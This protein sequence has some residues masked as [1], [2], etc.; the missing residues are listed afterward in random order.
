MKPNPY[1]DHQL[2]MAPFAVAAVLLLHVPRAHAN[3]FDIHCDPEGPLS[4]YSI[5]VSGELGTVFH[6]LVRQAGTNRV[7]ELVG[8]PAFVLEPGNHWIDVGALASTGFGSLDFWGQN[9]CPTPGWAAVQVRTLLLFDKSIALARS[10]TSA[11]KASMIR[12]GC[13]VNESI[14]VRETNS[15]YASVTGLTGPIPSGRAFAMTWA[16]VQPQAIAIQQEV[17]ARAVMTRVFPDCSVSSFRGDG[18]SQVEHL[19]VEVAQFT[20]C[21]V[22]QTV[23]RAVGAGGT[24]PTLDREALAPVSV[25]RGMLTAGIPEAFGYETGLGDTVFVPVR[26]YGYRFVGLTGN[27]IEGLLLPAGFTKTL[28]IKI[29]GKIVAEAPPGSAIVPAALVGHNVSDLTVLGFE[30]NDDP[31][32]LSL[33]IFSVS[34]RPP[35]DNGGVEIQPLIVPE[36]IVLPPGATEVEPG[37]SLTLSAI[38]IPSLPA[39]YQWSHAGTNL[40]AA[41]QLSLTLENFGPEMAGDYTLSVSND[42]GTRTSASIRLSVLE[43]LVIS[44]KGG[45]TALKWSTPGVVLKTALT[46]SGPWETVPGATS[47]FTVP[48]ATGNR[49][50]RLSQP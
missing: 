22:I 50:Y 44:S 37:A 40:P 27:N 17:I 36:P 49:F 19:G 47:P 10:E 6:S 48:A 13:Q 32:V 29:D 23:T 34:M 1:R 45:V 2:K 26:A 5:D 38:A 7:D 12:L 33:P 11:V 30:A 35:N 20:K 28:K 43:T 16:E 4:E 39:T 21:R 14:Q 8:D 15:L 24:V 42:I 3:P 18:S 9:Y 41:N 46:L 31:A 25:R